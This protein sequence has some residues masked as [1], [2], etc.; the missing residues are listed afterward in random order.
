MYSEGKIIVGASNG[1]PI[2]IY[3][4]KICRHGLIA[5]ATGTGKTTTL[6]VLAESFSDAGIPVF[7]ADVKGDLAGLAFEGEPSERI[8][9]RAEKLGLTEKGFHYHKFPVNFWDVF[10]KGGMPLRTT[11]SEMGPLLL[12]R[13][14]NLSETQSAILTI[15]FKIADDEDLLLIDTKDLKALL[16]FVSE[17][18]AEYSMQYGNMSSQ[19]LA[20]ILRAVIALETEGADKFIGEPAVN[21]QDFIDW[22]EDGQGLLQ[23][24]D[25]RE[26]FL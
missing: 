14:L 19:S 7:L 13:V 26:L 10:G 15:L 16:Q 25:C 12:S 20:S 21:I 1:E 4:S 2:C 23:V 24:L 8:D 9:S 11:V 18:R 5:G 6:K 17:N 3:P 22:N